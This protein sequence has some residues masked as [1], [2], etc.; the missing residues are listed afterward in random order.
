MS[1]LFASPAQDIVRIVVVVTLKVPYY[2][3]KI[4]KY[5]V[6]SLVNLR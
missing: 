5:Y 4:P 2:S 6:V 3:N 1:I